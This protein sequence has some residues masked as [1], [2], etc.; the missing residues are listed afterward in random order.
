MPKTQPKSGAKTWNREQVKALFK[1]PTFATFLVIWICH[2]IGGWGVSKVLPTVVYD[3]GMEGS[4]VSQ[5]MTM[6][7]DCY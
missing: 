3:L 2:A 7:S 5:L 6:V 4:A 1:D